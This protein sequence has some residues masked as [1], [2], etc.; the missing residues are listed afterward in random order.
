MF[1]A[2]NPL[3]NE[4]I[5]ALAE[6]VRTDNPSGPLYAETMGT[7]VAAQ[8]L[9]RSSCAPER[10]PMVRAASGRRLSV[11][12]ST[13]SRTTS[14]MQIRLRDLAAIAGM[15]TSSSSGGSRTRPASAS[16]VRDAPE[17]RASQAAAF[18]AGFERARCALA[19]GFASPSHFAQA[20][21]LVTGVTPRSYRSASGS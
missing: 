8:F 17:D 11:D 12:S 2:R 1:R 16:P 20:F 13:T 3:L 6:E 18:R 5:L 21:R 7:A 19:C 14:R 4:L 9:R 10:A 15:S